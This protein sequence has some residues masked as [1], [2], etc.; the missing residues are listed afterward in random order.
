MSQVPDWAKDS[1]QAAPDWALDTNSDN[2]AQSQNL[3]D[4]EYSNYTKL[5]K[6]PSTTGEVL[7]K[8]FSDRGYGTPTNAQQVLEFHRKN[9]DVAPLKTFNRLSKDPLAAA[10]PKD[11]QA[12]EGTV[13]NTPA[14]PRHWGLDP[15]T[16][17]ALGIQDM[18]DARNRVSPLRWLES[19]P[20]ATADT[21]VRGLQAGQY[22]I[23]QIAEWADKAYQGS[24][25]DKTV[26][27][28]TGVH[29]RPSELIGGLPEAFPLAGAE[30]GGLS[31]DLANSVRAARGLPVKA[32]PLPVIPEAPQTVPEVSKPNTNFVEDLPQFKSVAERQAEGSFGEKAKGYASSEDR[33]SK[34]PPT[35]EETLGKLTSALKSAQKATPEQQALYSQ[36]R[37]ER[38]G[39]AKAQL[40]SGDAEGAAKAFAQLKGELPKVDFAPLA[41]SV[42][43][44]EYDTLVNHIAQSDKLRG[45]E[46]F[47]ALSG[48]DKLM[49]GQLPPTSELE[50]L[51]RVLP[52]DFIKAALGKRSL[53]DKGQSAFSQIWNLP[54]S[55]VSTLD[56]SIPLRQGVFMVSRPEFYTSFGKMLK[57]MG[58]EKYFEATQEAIRSRPT[59]PLMEDSG[60]VIHDNKSLELGARPEQFRSNLAGKIPVFKH[61]YNISERGAEGF[62]NQLR[63]DVFDRMYS[64]YKQAGVDLHQN[65]ELAKKVADYINTATGR[66][67]VPFDKVGTLAGDLFFS[68]Q[69]MSSRIQLTS[70]PVKIAFEK[71]PILRK[72]MARDLVGFGGIASTVVALAALGGA[73]VSTDPLSTDWGKIRVPAQGGIKGALSTADSLFGTGVQTFKGETRHDI[74]G[75]LQQYAH[76]AAVLAANQRTTINGKTVDFSKSSKDNENRASVVAKFLRSKESP[77]TSLIHDYM[78][79][80]DYLGNKFDLKSALVKRLVPFSA[81]DLQEG[82]DPNSQ[83]FDSSNKPVIPPTTPDVAT[84]D[85]AK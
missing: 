82:Y 40:E 28:I 84:P 37:K 49:K 21:L 66:G 44:Q 50:K 9:P 2:K 78:A 46:T 24:G 62:S 15:E 13:L 10:L 34:E 47:G 54:R 17:K 38:L 81:Q 77:M 45:Y 70:L 31:S 23:D 29:Q 36:A 6:D 75:G 76:L 11:Q 69:L 73:K 65:P 16:L 26:T 4:Q 18:T 25:V 12:P 79:D 80:S 20:A 14:E 7:S 51:R 56:A 42:S 43:P 48:L 35:V 8:W 71:D 55:L 64:Q 57:Q 72:N 61:L 3:T 52:E 67:K 85:W 30:L 60:L 32:E 39:A 33:V 19:L 22:G 58:S 27:D 41:N 83:V 1:P 68:P 74:F 53:L 63:A 5:L 59:F